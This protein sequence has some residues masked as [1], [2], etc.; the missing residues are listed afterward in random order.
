MDIKSLILQPSDVRFLPI[1]SAFVK[2][3]GVVEEIN[4]LCPSEKD[5]SPGHV[6]MALI[7][8]TLSGRSPLYRLERSFKDMDLE[9][10]LG[11]DIEPSKL[12]T[13]VG[14]F[15]CNPFDEVQLAYL[16]ALGLSQEIFTKG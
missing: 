8:D 15:L 11:V 16:Q 5:V 12:R 6:I 4:R 1:V 7:L 9:L 3:I 14:R 2:K 10:L 13:N